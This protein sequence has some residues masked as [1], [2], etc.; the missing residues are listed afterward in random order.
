MFKI[1]ITETRSV[2]MVQGPQWKQVGA[3]EVRR[4]YP[5]AMGGETREEPVFGYTPEIETIQEV[6]SK[7][8]EQEVESLDLV[9]VIKAINK[10]P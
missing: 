2:Q 5:T 8:L 4:E 7:V 10:I 9:A 1:T 6:T 3:K